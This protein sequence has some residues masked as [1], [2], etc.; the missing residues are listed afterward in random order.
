MVDAPPRHNRGQ[1]P[2][3]FVL[4]VCRYDSP[5][6]LTDH[7]LGRVAED[8]LSRTIPRSDNPRDILAH[9]RVVGGLDD[10][11]EEETCVVLLVG[12]LRHVQTSLWRYCAA[13]LT[14]RR[15]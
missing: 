14:S 13:T 11:G 4:A 15:W 7:L 5:D 3:L 10:G 12:H 6:G 8:S 9:D 2:V 1:H